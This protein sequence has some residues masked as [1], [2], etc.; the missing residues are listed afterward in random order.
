MELLRRSFE[1]LE[2]DDHVTCK[3]RALREG[4]LAA[5][6]QANLSTHYAELLRSR[7]RDAREAAGAAA[8]RNR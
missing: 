8:H 1:G 3:P 7:D 5:L 2:T 4:Y 6:N